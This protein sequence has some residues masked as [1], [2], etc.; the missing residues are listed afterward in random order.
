M[1]K[2]RIF[3]FILSLAGVVAAF[4]QRPVLR[5]T[6]T[7]S[8]TGETLPYASVMCRDTTRISYSWI[9]PTP[10]EH[11]F[12]A[13]P[14]DSSAEITVRVTDRFGNVYTAPASKLVYP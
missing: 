2:G 12:K 13:V 10:T 1:L 5:G 4:A 3:L 14:S 6:V 9:G 8:I 7:D 11:L